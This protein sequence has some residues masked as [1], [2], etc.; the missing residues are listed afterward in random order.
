MLAA[1]AVLIGYSQQKEDKAR[2]ETAAGNAHLLQERATNLAE[3]RRIDTI[4]EQG[5]LEF[6]GGHSDQALI[7]LRGICEAAAGQAVRHL[8]TPHRDG[9]RMWR[10][11][12]QK[13]AVQIAGL[14]PSGDRMLTVDEEATRLWEKN[15]R[16][17]T[18]LTHNSAK[19]KIARSWFADERRELVTVTREGGID[20]WDRDGSWL[21]RIWNEDPRC[22][23]FEI[24]ADRKN[25]HVFCQEQVSFVP[26]NGR[27]PDS[28][29]AAANLCDV[30][31]GGKYIAVIAGAALEVHDLAGKQLVRNFTKE[32]IAGFSSVQW[33]ESGDYVIA[34]SGSDLI[35]YWPFSEPPSD[36]SVPYSP[37]SVITDSAGK[38]M[39]TMG[40]RG[41]TILWRV[42]GR[43][44]EISKREIG[45]HPPSGRSAR[46]RTER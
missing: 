45:A 40:Y 19:P 18:T 30:D 24:S 20:V 10:S 42:N 11:I 43:R 31:A 23:R 29:P 6:L 16:L 14:S 28:Y 38:S 21:R 15:G 4:Q 8:T 32:G 26:V 17:V 13:G 33:S 12:L 2:A 46:G 34:A 39:V 27:P 7:H 44:H 22:T 41:S 5:R 36:T 37:S 25:L 9:S 1:I 3:E 35:L